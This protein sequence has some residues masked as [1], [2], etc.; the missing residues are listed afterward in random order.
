MDQFVTFREKGL[1]AR[2]DKKKLYNPIRWHH[3]FQDDEDMNFATPFPDSEE[4]GQAEIQDI[5]SE[6]LSLTRENFC[7][8]SNVFS[9]KTIPG[10]PRLE[11]QV[12]HL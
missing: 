9:V 11:A 6:V 4:A 2:K 7:S 3:L 8:Q 5:P 1:L 10:N 12:S